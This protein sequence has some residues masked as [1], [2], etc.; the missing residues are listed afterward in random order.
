MSGAYCNLLYHLVFSTKERRPLIAPAFKPRLLE[1][2]RG[3]LREHEGELLELDG[4]ADHVHL[5]ARLHHDC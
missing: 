2:I 4:V 1:Y 3:I 5:L